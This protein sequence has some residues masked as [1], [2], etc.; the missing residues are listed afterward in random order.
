[1][2]NRYLFSMHRSC[3]PLGHTPWRAHPFSAIW[4]LGGALSRSVSKDQKHRC[5]DRRLRHVRLGDDA[6]QE[7]CQHGRG[8]LPVHTRIE[9]LH[10]T[11]GWEQGLI[12]ESL[13]GSTASR[14]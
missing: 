1:M 7:A 5:H 10:A 6:G 12:T 3:S 13:R 11:K 4:R 8:A 14:R 9:I 2:T